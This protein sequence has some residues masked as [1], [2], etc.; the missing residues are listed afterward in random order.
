MNMISIVVPVYC[1][2]DS[3]LSWLVNTSGER[4][5]RLVTGLYMLLN[6]S[7]MNQQENITQCTQTTNMMCLIT[8]GASFKD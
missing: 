8:N 6:I 2:A 1:N 7:F 5:N 4:W 3:L